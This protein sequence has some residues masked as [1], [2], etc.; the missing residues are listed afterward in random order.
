MQT[1]VCYVHILITKQR[2][3]SVK[4]N[5]KNGTAGN[6]VCHTF[7]SSDLGYIPNAIYG[8]STPENFAIQEQIKVETSAGH[9]T[10]GAFLLLNSLHFK[11]MNSFMKNEKRVF[12]MLLCTFQKIHSTLRLFLGNKFCLQH[13]V[14]SVDDVSV[15]F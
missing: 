12:E 14:Y 15:L 4:T 7:D 10:S 6:D 9:K 2:Q 1:D 13:F 5:K 3:H 11:S 8:I